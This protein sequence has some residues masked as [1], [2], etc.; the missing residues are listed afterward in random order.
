MTYQIKVILCLYQEQNAKPQQ[1]RL[2]ALEKETSQSTKQQP[3]KQLELEKQRLERLEQQRARAAEREKAIALTQLTVNSL[4]AVSK[5]AAEGGILAPF[6]IAST[7]I[8]LLAGFASARTA[9]E[10]AFFEGTEYVD[11]HNKY[12]AGRDTVPARLHKGSLLCAKVFWH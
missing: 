9:S 5:A 11:P 10:N 12:P 1:K 2:H 3:K 6:T 4:V 7:I 8:A